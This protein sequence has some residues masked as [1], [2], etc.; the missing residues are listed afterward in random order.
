[1]H[2]HCNE[3]TMKQGKLG[4]LIAAIGFAILLKFDSSRW[5]FG[6]YDLQTYWMTSQ[7]NRAPVLSYVYAL[8]IIS[9]PSVN[10]NWANNPETLNSG[11]K[12]GNCLCRVNLNFDRWPWNTTWHVLYATSSFVYHFIAIGQFKLGLQS[13][14][15]QFGSKSTI[16]CPVR[17]WNLTDNLEI[18]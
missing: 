15:S 13:G 3:L 14:N 11:V 6:A 2:A 16:F 9:K 10:S 17:P 1:M 8:C 12:I 5:F 18:Q 4:D 7:N